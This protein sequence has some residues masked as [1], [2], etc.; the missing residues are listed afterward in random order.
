LVRVA[1]EVAAGC[2]MLAQ[3]VDVGVLAAQYD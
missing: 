3:D 1:V 2:V